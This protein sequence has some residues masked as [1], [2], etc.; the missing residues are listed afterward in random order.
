VRKVPFDLQRLQYLVFSSHKSATQT[1]KSTLVKNGF[2]AMHCH[3][4]RNVHIELEPGELAVQ[5]SQRGSGSPLKIISVFREPI[6]R[7][8]SSMFQWC[9][10]GVVRWEMVADSSQTVIATKSVGE[11]QRYMYESYIPKYGYNDE[12]IF[13]I[14]S[15]LGIAPSGLRFDEDQM[16]GVNRLP[17]CIV[18]LL[19]FDQLISNTVSTLAK[20]IGREVVIHKSNLSGDKWY[21]EKYIEFCRELRL[22][23]ATI[24]S[25]YEERRE[26]IEL[27]YPNRF[28]EQLDNAIERYGA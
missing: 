9:G 22:P 15:E 20:V 11:L 4:L 3:S 17:G 16:V 12:S 18:Y 13:E 2:P 10:V 6:E 1:L 23:M 21:R 19:R 5:L 8:S 25:V 26:L 14:C 24:K 7:L 28:Q 27:F